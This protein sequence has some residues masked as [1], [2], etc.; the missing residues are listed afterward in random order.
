MV[1]GEIRDRTQVTGL[2]ERVVVNCTGLGSGALFGDS[3]LMPV[4]GQLTFLFP[5][6]EVDYLAISDGLYM[7]PRSDGIL[8]G[9]TFDRGNADLAFDFEAERRILDGHRR[10]FS[11][12]RSG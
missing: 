6:P 1:V 7:F 4:K 2:S 8:L 5:Q 10:L 9:G 12:M 3:E 11:S